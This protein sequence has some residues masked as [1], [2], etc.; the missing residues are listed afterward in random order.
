M[1]VLFTNVSYVKII[2]VIE[3][4]KGEE[5]FVKLMGPLFITV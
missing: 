2:Q 1:K 5:H 3:K 4:G